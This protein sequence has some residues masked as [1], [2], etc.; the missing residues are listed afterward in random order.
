[1]YH[2]PGWALHCCVHGKRYEI[3]RGNPQF[4]NPA[5]E[6]LMNDRYLIRWRPSVGY[7]TNS[8]ATPPTG[9]RIDEDTARVH[10]TIVPVY[11]K[12]MNLLAEHFRG[13]G[14]SAR[15]KGEVEQSQG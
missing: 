9:N 7:S 5:E 15:K 1:M 8:Q 13:L 12:K 14:D 2:Q 6:C 10:L 11:L 4:T 3:D